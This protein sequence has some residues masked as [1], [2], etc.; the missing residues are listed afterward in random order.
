MDNV[1]HVS[2]EAYAEICR[3]L[4]TARALE[5]EAKGSN[6]T[7]RAKLDLLNAAKS[8]RERAMEIQ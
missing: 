1:K 2:P 4:D 6:L 7:L 3:L 8:H 5:D